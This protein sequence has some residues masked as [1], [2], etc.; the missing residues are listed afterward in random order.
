MRC[1][2]GHICAA[3][4]TFTDVAGEVGVPIPGQRTEG[5]RTQGPC[6]RRGG[7]ASASPPGTEG[8][9]GLGASGA[10]LQVGTAEMGQLGSRGPGHSRGVTLRPGWEGG[11]CIPEQKWDK[12]PA[13]GPNSTCHLPHNNPDRMGT[14][15]LTRLGTALHT[16]VSGVLATLLPTSESLAGSG[17]LSR[18]LLT[19]E[20]LLCPTRTQASPS[21]SGLGGQTRAGA[22]CSGLPPSTG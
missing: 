20:T 11:A 10:Q 1:A 12:E 2:C 19:V 8:V 14:C 6:S 7:S 21:L 5:L 13:P 18:H 15:P 22:F 9:G 4:L 3:S 16:V 17:S